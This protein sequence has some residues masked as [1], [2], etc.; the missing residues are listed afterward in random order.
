MSQ[1]ICTLN[2]GYMWLKCTHTI[3]LLSQYYLRC[4]PP[5]QT[6][7]KASENTLQIQ[8]MITTHMHYVYLY[9]G[10]Y[11]GH[12]ISIDFNVAPCNPGQPAVSAK[13]VL[14]I[15]GCVEFK[16]IKIL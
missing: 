8:R 3:L 6:A 1:N 14:R 2:N 4:P 10:K 15:I 12:I 9:V 16:F 5:Q 11:V 13:H 7:T